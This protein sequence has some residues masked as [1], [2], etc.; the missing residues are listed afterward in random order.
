M[1]NIW[2]TISLLN[3]ILAISLEL[4]TI[5]V[6]KDIGYKSNFSI[7][8]IIKMSFEF[9]L[10]TILNCVP[11]IHIKFLFS[12]LDYIF[13]SK[14]M[15]IKEFI[16]EAGEKNKG[17][18]GQAEAVVPLK[19]MYKNIRGIVREELANISIQIDGKEFMRATAPYQ[20]EYE[21]YNNRFA[22]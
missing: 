18:Q 16:V 2:L 6:L 8:Q 14:R 13:M 5:K 20:D 3:V 7:N 21:S 10:K 1:F 15:F 11:I 17:R 4:R 19:S 9:L 22:Y 12:K